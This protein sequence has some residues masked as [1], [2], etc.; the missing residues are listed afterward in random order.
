MHHRHALTWLCVLF[1][2]EAVSKVEFVTLKVTFQMGVGTGQG[3]ECPMSLMP[4]VES[5]TGGS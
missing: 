1:F 4:A 5:G 3:L 2:K